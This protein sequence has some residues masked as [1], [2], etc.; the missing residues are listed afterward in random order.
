MFKYPSF[1]II[2]SKRKY[3]KIYLWRFPKLRFPRNWLS[4]RD[5]QEK[6]QL[7]LSKRL[8]RRDSQEK[9]RLAIFKSS[10]WR[11]F[12]VLICLVPLVMW[13]SRG[14][15]NDFSPPMDSRHHVPDYT[16]KNF[17]TIQMDEHG[18]LK[19]QLAAATMTHYPD[20]NTELTAPS[21]VFYKEKQP[22]WM[23]RAKQGEV[24]PDGNQVWLLGDTTLQQHTQGPQKAVEI[25]SQDVRLQL[26]TEYA[27]T[28][29]PTTIINSHGKTH[30]V[31]MRAFMP[32]QQVELLSQVRGHYV[33]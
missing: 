23:V 9:P 6:P 27:E 5:S 31:G 30:S 16:L 17:K 10:Y 33:P 28:A 19:T 12:V 1:L 25:I 14:L 21:M 20:I 4:K 24:S 8:S 13:L 7:V 18:Q 22:T 3:I 11:G 15:E 2:T 32:S 29:A 26:D